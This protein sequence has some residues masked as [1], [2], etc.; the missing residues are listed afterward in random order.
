MGRFDMV[1]SRASPPKW[2]PF[3]KKTVEARIFNHSRVIVLTLKSHP[4][5]C[6]MDGLF[7]NVTNKLTG[8]RW[9][10]RSVSS[11]PEYSKWENIFIGL[12]ISCSFALWKDYD[13]DR[14]VQILLLPEAQNAREPLLLLLFGILAWNCGPQVHRATEILLC[15]EQEERSSAFGR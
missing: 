9:K 5:G 10:P 6:R 11:L 3:P 2:R 8:N 14:H 12:F 1:V 4:G 7:R 13:K 15:M